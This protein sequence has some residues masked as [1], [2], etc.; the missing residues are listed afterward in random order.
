METPTNIVFFLLIC[1]V[2]ISESCVELLV[3]RRPQRWQCGSR[4]RKIHDKDRK[5]AASDLW[6][7]FSTCFF[8]NFAN[9]R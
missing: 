4:Q 1:R 7:N 3:R 9:E 8:Y 2:P 5:E 6:E